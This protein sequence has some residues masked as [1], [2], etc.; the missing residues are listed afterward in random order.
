M[1]FFTPSLFVAACCYASDTSSD[2][3]AESLTLPITESPEVLHPFLQSF[4]ARLLQ[5]DRPLSFALALGTHC[6]ITTCSD[7]EQEVKVSKERLLE[8]MN[9]EYPTP[10]EQLNLGIINAE[11][12]KPTK[13][14]FCEFFRTDSLF[15]EL[16]D[17]DSQMPVMKFRSA[18]STFV[19]SNDVMIYIDLVILQWFA[20]AIRSN[21]NAKLDPSWIRHLCILITHKQYRNCFRNDILVILAH[22]QRLIDSKIITRQQI[23]PFLNLLKI[24]PGDELIAHFI[25]KFNQ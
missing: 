21:P 1:N 5:F 25:G 6:D 18:M 13:N 12:P 23:L 4:E 16:I 14:P 7:A 24:I 11:Y 2:K 8:I 17:I 20:N 15:M 9:A 3:A 19:K 22:V 10:T